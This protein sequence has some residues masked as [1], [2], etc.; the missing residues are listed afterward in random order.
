M[1]NLSVFCL[2]LC[3]RTRLEVELHLTF[4]ACPRDLFFTRLKP[5]APP[6]RAKRLQWKTALINHLSIHASIYSH[7]A[8]LYS[9]YLRKL[10]AK[11]CVY[12]SVSVF[13]ATEL[14]KR[15]RNFNQDCAN[16]ILE[17]T[18]CIH[19]M[20]EIGGNEKRSQPKIVLA[21]LSKLLCFFFIF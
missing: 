18:Y 5:V 6:R 12:C 10:L 16:S 20:Y 1:S 2:L 15:R 8:I 17:G 13:D 7:W 4:L 3:A 19:C 21:Y 11:T 9:I 14:R